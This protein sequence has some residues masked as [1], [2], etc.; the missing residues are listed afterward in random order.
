[1]KLEQYGGKVGGY[2]SEKIHLA[3]SK[4]QKENCG[5]IVHDNLCFEPLAE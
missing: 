3:K 5:F 2:S 1:M 4:S